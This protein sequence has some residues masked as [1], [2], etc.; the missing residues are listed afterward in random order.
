MQAWKEIFLKEFSNSP[1]VKHFT[2]LWDSPQE[3][4]GD[5]SEFQK[6]GFQVDFSVVL[7]AGK[8]RPPKRV[9]AALEI[10]VLSSDSNWKAATE[11]QIL[12]KS[13]NFKETEF[14]VFKERQMAR[15]WEMDAR[16]LGH[17]FGAF[18]EGKLVGDLGI[19]K[20]GTIGRFQ[21]VETHPDFLR[22]GI[23]GTLVYRSAQFAFEKMGVKNLV[24][25]ADEN[26]H[27]ARIYESVGFIPGAK[28]Y[29]AFI[30]EKS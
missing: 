1:E 21:S 19:F 8:V 4:S 16:G 27:A 26:Y 22:Q 10:R 6:E 18:L 28:E 14:R 5:V 15:Y 3:G 20:E 7:T 24:M 17:W 2:F 23:C 9:N 29:S 13:A 30:W 12:S 11:N 25:V